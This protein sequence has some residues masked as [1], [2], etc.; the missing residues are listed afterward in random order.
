MDPEEPIENFDKLTIS[1]IFE[2]SSFLV[3]SQFLLPE[4]LQSLNV[5]QGEQI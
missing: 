3:L 2:K 1:K 5:F 4:A